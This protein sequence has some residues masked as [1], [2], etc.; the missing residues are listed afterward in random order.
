MTGISCSSSRTAATITAAIM[1]PKSG[2]LL[3]ESDCQLYALG[4]FDASDMKRTTEEREGPGLLSELAALT[5][6]HVF[7][8]AKLTELVDLSGKIGTEL[9]SQYI[10]GYKPADLRHDG[11][12]RRIKVALTPS[13]E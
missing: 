3:K 10:L 2:N 9:R 11:R 13:H 5:G 4:I 12:W 8:T 7:Q 1:K 6:G